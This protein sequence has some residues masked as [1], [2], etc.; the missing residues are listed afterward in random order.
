MFLSTT[1]GLIPLKMSDV[2]FLNHLMMFDL[3]RHA[4]GIK[5]VRL[6]GSHFG[7]V[8]IIATVAT[9]GTRP[10]PKYYIDEGYFGSQ[11]N[12][13]ATDVTSVPLTIMLPRGQRTDALF[14]RTPDPAYTKYPKLKANVQADSLRLRIRSR[15][16]I[17]PINLEDDPEDLEDGE[18]GANV[19][20]WYATLKLVSGKLAKIFIINDV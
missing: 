7:D 6:H 9:S 2:Y 20:L 13:S 8:T 15:S 12:P 11:Y 1:T 19:L 10:W 14:V 17:S 18:D 5:K 16:F 4:D 3:R